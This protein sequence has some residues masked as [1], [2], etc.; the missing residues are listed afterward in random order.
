MVIGVAVGVPVVLAIFLIGLIFFRR[1]GMICPPRIKET[2]AHANAAYM[3]TNDDVSFSSH[4]LSSNDNEHQHRDN[5]S[6]RTDNVYSHI[7][8]QT[9][10]IKGQHL[11]A[12]YSNEKKP[13]HTTRDTK[14]PA[15]KTT[16][17][18]SD[19]TCFKDSTKLVQRNDHDHLRE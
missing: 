8:I 18:E 3:V 19:N 7:N 5:E 12:P 17:Q 11:R 13:F 14:R 1:R 6:G 2:D 4:A 9:P 16:I 10:K 15:E